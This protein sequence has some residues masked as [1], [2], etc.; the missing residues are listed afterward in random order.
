M[1]SLRETWKKA[2]SL[3]KKGVKNSIDAKL[4]VVVKKHQKYLENM[5]A[6]VAKVKEAGKDTAKLEEFV[7]QFKEHTSSV[8]AKNAELKDATG[9][10][11]KT[12]W[13]ELRDDLKKSKD[14]LRDFMKEFRVGDGDD[15][16]D[17]KDEA[18]SENPEEETTDEE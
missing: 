2:K 13:K 8:E 9:D 10:E 1:K 12:A 6:K 14:I 17:D 11:W 3:Q 7:T 5:E 15:S 4:D 16:D 18:E